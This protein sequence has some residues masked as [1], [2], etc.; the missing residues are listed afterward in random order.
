M[1]VAVLVHGEEILEAAGFCLENSVLDSRP[2]RL[3]EVVLPT[4]L[5]ALGGS[6]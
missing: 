1:E 5:S 2:F 4:N 3:D 6:R